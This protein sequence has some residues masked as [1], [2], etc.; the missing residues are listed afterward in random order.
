M[1]KILE[2]LMDNVKS[3]PSGATITPA[4]ETTSDKNPLIILQ[5]LDKRFDKDGNIGQS[6]G[7]KG[8][9]AKRLD[10]ILEELKKS[11]IGSKGGKEVKR[12]GKEEQAKEESTPKKYIP[13]MGESIKSSFGTAKKFVT[14]DAKTIRNVLHDTGLIKKGTGAMF[15]NALERAENKQQ[16]IRDRLDTQGT[17]FGSKKSFA[18]SFEKSEAVKRDI[19]KNDARI[20]ELRKSGFKEEQIKRGGFFKKATELQTN[21]GEVDTRYSDSFG[22]PKKALGDKRNIIA[23]KQ[24]PKRETKKAKEKSYGDLD[25]LEMAKLAGHDNVAD[26]YKE[27]NTKAMSDDPKVAKQAQIDLKA[28]EKNKSGGAEAKPK[29]APRKAAKKDVVIEASEQPDDLAPKKAPKRTTKK[30]KEMAATQMYWEQMVG[31]KQNKNSDSVLKSTSTATAEQAKTKS[32]GEESM[33]AENESNRKMEEQNKLLSEIEKHTKDTAESLKKPVTT[34][35]APQ[36]T[37]GGGMGGGILGGIGAGLKA[38]GKGIGGLGK[39]IGDAIKGILTGISDGIASFGKKEVL[40][41]AAAL[42]ILSGSLYIASKALQEF[43]KVDWE[44]IAK[45]GVTLLGLA[46][47]AMLLGKAGPEMIIGAAAIGILGAALWVT[48]KALEMFAGL[49]WETIGKGFA[50]LAG[51]GVIGAI[52]GTAA[53]LILLGAAAIGA[54]GLAL[55]PFAAAMAIAAPSMDQF[56]DGMKKLGEVGGGTLLG[57][58][59][60]L[61]ALGAAM[62]AFG[63]G[64]AAAGLGNLVS[65]LLSIGSDSPIEQLIK[66]GKAGPG[67]AQAADGMS[68]LAD[69]MA[70]FSKLSPI[71]SKTIKS[72]KE[73]AAIAP[74]GS[75]PSPATKAG[76]TGSPSQ[77]T[78]PTSQPKAAPKEGSPEWMKVNQPNIDSWVKAVQ[79]GSKKI[80]DVPTV[81]KPYVQKSVQ[82]QPKTTTQEKDVTST[83]M[84]AEKSSSS[85][86]LKPAISPASGVE[87]DNRS[88]ENAKAAV[89]SKAPVATS[90]NTTTV[91]ANKSTTVVVK[92]PIRNPDT[93]FATQASAYSG[94]GSV[95]GH[96]Y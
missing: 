71:D 74:P 83:A 13:T 22:G 39:G 72:M 44:S 1:K 84:P 56:A 28:Y 78:T 70:K 92:P 17:T 32:V 88:A 34:E 15:S 64:Q 63:A 40:Q 37:S 59:A 55:I 31:D 66:I 7:E 67:I 45:G 53:P 94:M 30:D 60:G 14:G 11:T 57:V 93:S 68:K 48:G 90:N 21:L 69:A 75:A 58:A 2:K 96:L 5:K 8:E 82:Q 86:N 26:W 20:S 36:E 33:E 54:M 16:Y 29:K 52:A 4:P 27:T 73:V 41:G 19:E 46:G 12:L 76:G 24:A 87:I 80:D 6:L 43:N 95:R 49:E 25:N 18:A 62:V 51:L 38:L 3:V 50:A 47:V 77:G 10:S 89:P 9:I 61:T 85:A 65:N 81:Y 91:N 79:S 42:V 23:P 35:A